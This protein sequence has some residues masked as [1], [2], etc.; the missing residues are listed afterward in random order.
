MTFNPTPYDLASAAVYW[1]TV[2]G[3]FAALALFVAFVT[4]VAALGLEGPKAFVARLRDGVV[5]FTRLSCRRIWAISMLT[6]REAVRRKALAVFVVF[7]ILFMFAGWFLPD[8]DIRSDLQVKTYVS[9]VLRWTIP[10]LLLPVVLLLSCWGIPEDIRARSLHTVVTK[11]V[12]RSEIIIGRILG[13]TLVSTLL[14]AAMST[15]GYIWIQRQLPPEVQLVSR[16]P[17]YGKISYLNREGRGTDEHGNEFRGLNTGDIWEF[18]GYIEGATKSR[19]IW[20]FQNVT[21]SD[22]IKLESRFEA[23]RTHKGEMGKGLLCRFIFVN[24]DK[25]LRVPMPAFEVAEFTQNVNEYDRKLTYYDENAREMKTVDLFD[26]LAPD[27]NL[28]IEVQALDAGQYI[29]MAQSDLFLRMPDRS[30]FSGYAKST[31]GIWLLLILVVVLGVTASCFVKGP[32][33]TLLVF[34]LLIVGQ[35]FREFMGKL[36]AGQQ[37]GGGP[38]EATY[39]LVKHMNPTTALPETTLSWVIQQVD[40]VM[41]N[42]LWLVQN[43]VPNFGY[44]NMSPYPANGFDV[45]WSAAL[46][47]S[48][49]VTAAYLVPCL[50]LAYYSLSLRELEAK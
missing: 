15:V 32:V 33:A 30:F 40:A 4:S 29:G 25:G 31:L 18:R 28:R 22:K 50:L 48:I 45:P 2:F 23:F 37:E 17:V 44:F 26:D 11:P 43:I 10:W 47:P 38:F 20:D 46:L 24:E 6:F 39:R 35:G 3:G 42:G 8:V 9:F 1:L 27:G 16:V 19:A 49:V 5:D 41:I 14:V 13:L 12:R 7:A 34:S 21:P 36:V